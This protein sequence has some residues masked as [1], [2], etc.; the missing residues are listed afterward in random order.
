MSMPVFRQ[1]PYLAERL[2]LVAGLKVQHILDRE[3]VHIKVLTQPLYL[4]LCRIH[5]AKPEEVRSFPVYG[6]LACRLVAV[7]VLRSPLRFRIALVL[8]QNM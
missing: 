4:F 6:L 7:P 1:P 8:L 2:H 3:W 5:Y